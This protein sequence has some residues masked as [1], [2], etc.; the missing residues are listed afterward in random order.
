MITLVELLR[1]YEGEE[2][3]CDEQPLMLAPVGD[4]PNV[5]VSDFFFII[6]FA[7]PQN[8]QTVMSQPFIGLPDNFHICPV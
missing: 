3:K 4:E 5:S 1:L 7:L 6:L 8:T 2:L